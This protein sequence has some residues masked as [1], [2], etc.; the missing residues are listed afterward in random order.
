MPKFRLA[1]WNIHKGVRGIGPYKRLEVNQIAHGVAALEAD[2]VCLQE[3]RNIDHR[4]AQRFDFWPSE[5]QAS[6]LTPDGFHLA[7]H[8]NAFNRHGEHGNALVSR[9]PIDAQRQEDV[10]HHPFEQRGLLHVML[11]VEGLPL[12]VVVVHLGLMEGSRSW[13]I[14]RLKQL[15]HDHIPREHALVVAGDFND[16]AEHLHLPLEDIHLRSISPGRVNTYPSRAP[17]LPLDRIYVRGL[18]LHRLHVPPRRHAQLH[19][20]KMSDHLPLLG[21]LEW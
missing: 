13:Q 19:W 3:V 14:G 12:H 9:F 15:I 8:S 6:F 4:Y 16:W 18:H 21:E 2:I 10:S 11:C 7:Y 17:I 20:P 5:P 1:T